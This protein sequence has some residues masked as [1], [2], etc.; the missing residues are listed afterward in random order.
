MLLRRQNDRHFLSIQ[1]QKAQLAPEKKAGSESMLPLRGMRPGDWGLWPC[2][3]HFC[4]PFQERDHMICTELSCIESMTKS[5]VCR[6]Q[7]WNRFGEISS[8]GAYT[9]GMSK[10]EGSKHAA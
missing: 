5:C 1:V 10:V 3:R 6:V 7:K 2:A 4:S 9:F 8:I